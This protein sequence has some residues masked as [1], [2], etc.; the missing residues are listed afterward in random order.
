MKFEKLVK[1]VNNTTPYNVTDELTVGKIYKAVGG[2]GSDTIVINDEGYEYSYMNSRFISV[3]DEDTLKT[4]RSEYDQ[5]IK[6]R[7]E[8]NEKVFTTAR[9]I[10]D[11][12]ILIDNKTK[13]TVGSRWKDNKSGD[14]YLVVRTS[15]DYL[16]VC[17]RDGGCWQFPKQNI[18]DIF[19][20]SRD[21]FTKLP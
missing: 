4:L 19:G 5:L 7:D 16:L 12:K 8:L 13:V 1:C 21:R 11:L 10:N 20:V 17:L 14:E 6:D 15:N 18:E 3:D 9:E 2:C